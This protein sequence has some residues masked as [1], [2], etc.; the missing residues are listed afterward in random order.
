[1]FILDEI[2]KTIN[3]KYGQ[4]SYF[5]NDQVIGKSLEFY[6]EWAQIEVDFLG[7]FIQKNDTVI[8]IGAFIGT[9]SLAFAEMVGPGG[10]VFSYEPNNISYQVL[11]N[12][13]DQNNH[14]NIFPSKI[15]LSNENIKIYHDDKHI[16]NEKN[17]GEFSI[18]NFVTSTGNDNKKNQIIISTLDNFKF[19]QCNLIKVDVEGMELNVLEGAKQ[20]IVNHQP[21]IFIEC[22]SLQ[23]GWPTIQFMKSINYSPF[24]FI[25]EAFN[26]ENYFHNKDNFF[27]QARETNLIFFPKETQRIRGHEKLSAIHTID[28]L[29]LGLILKPQY[30]YEVLKNTTITQKYGESFW[31]NQIELLHYRENEIEIEQ[32][33]QQAEIINLKLTE[34]N[35]S[36]ESDNNQLRNSQI[37]ANQLNDML[38][39]ENRVLFETIKELR[40][41]I[42][43]AE[44]QI[45]EIQQSFGYKIVLRIQAF[46]AKFLPV[47]SPIREKLK[48]FGVRLIFS[49]RVKKIKPLFAHYVFDPDWYLRTYP[50]VKLAQIDPFSHYLRYGW[51]EGRKPIED[52]DPVWYLSFYSDVKESGIE[53][54]THY[55]AHGIKEGRKP[56]STTNQNNSLVLL[57]NSLEA[58][59]D[60]INFPE[61]DVIIP[62]YHQPELLKKLLEN[63]ETSTDVPFNL[64]LINDSWMDEEVNNILVLAKEKFINIEI[65]QNPINLGFVKSVNLGLRKSRNHVVIMNTD[66]ELPENWLSRLIFP[67]MENEKIASV[68]PL[69]NSGTIA[70]FPKILVDNN[71][72]WNLDVNQVDAAF[73]MFSPRI[74]IET[75]TG[76]GFCMAI[77]RRA[78]LKIGVFDEDMFGK[79]YGEE[80]DWCRRAIRNGFFNVITPA[81]FVYHKHGGSFSTP[82][83]KK[84]ISANLVKLVKRHPDYN[85]AVSDFVTQDPLAVFRIFGLIGL[86]IKESGRKL[87]VILDHNLGGGANI[88]T[89]QFC[90]KEKEIRPILKISGRGIDFSLTVLFKDTE[91]ISKFSGWE[92]VETI[93]SNLL[94][95][96]IYLNNLVGYAQP[97]E[98]LD[99]IIDLKN[100]NDLK[101]TIPTHDY[102]CICPSY[103]LL[104]DKGVFCNIPRDLSIC[105]AC[106][107]HNKF[108]LTYEKSIMLWR[109]KWGNL[110]EYADS[111][112]VF[113][114]D[115]E[116][117]MRK[118]FPSVG[119]KI[120]VIPHS[121]TWTPRPVKIDP[122]TDKL[123]IGVIGSINEQK[124]LNVIQQLGRYLNKRE[125]RIII[126]GK[127]SENIESKA[128]KIIGKYERTDL[129]RL[130]E[131][132]A[133]N[134][135]FFSS[136]W[137]ETFSYVTHEVTA[138]QIPIVCFDIGAQAEKV[139]LYQKGKIIPL[140]S[141]NY[142]IIEALRSIAFHQIDLSVK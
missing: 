16:I 127:T 72:L 109:S 39:Q 18:S 65:I 99:S 14:T 59:S 73:R 31:A 116:K 22:L 141:G 93:L 132:E 96:E 114:H 36:L 83:K 7:Q 57:V 105:D 51:R 54:F 19:Y 111:L 135:I 121:L 27:E 89:E 8:D 86:A 103:N 134:V 85:H 45:S 64:I 128:I 25:S 84:L 3:C 62:I 20:T 131:K 74:T 15:A 2:L 11:L 68:T 53:P 48:N 100:K 107:Q 35:H 79:G 26:E 37:E 63:L 115:S 102:F 138:M 129:P 95:E 4:V 118:A 61:I 75:P 29:A 140:N 139:K 81:L 12:N 90:R 124:G 10:K 77:N 6:G 125:E 92:Q 130:I 137:P 23:N 136:I 55:L 71:M 60:E 43:K 33:L 32:K 38:K 106:A 119:N 113:S 80:N 9:F 49:L 110:L 104:N 13:I 69:T 47:G 50:D 98:V 42:R 76:V 44:N 5:K 28:D 122:A 70:S 78:I 82:E 40:T 97:L 30:K 46:I 94:I 67:I 91:L 56:H 120:D 123:R 41:S 108:F 87:L 142:E 21:I 117:I 101:I 112:I 133:I 34:K 52:F 24:L 58:N 66:I 88:F 17:P 1:M 126:F